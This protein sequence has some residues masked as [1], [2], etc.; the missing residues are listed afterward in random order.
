LTDTTISGQLASF[1]ADLRYEEIPAEVAEHAKLCLLD[2]LGCALFGSALPWTSILEE[3]LEQV[4]ADLPAGTGLPIWGTTSRL[5]APHAAMV[6]GAAAHAFELDD[7]HRESILHAG[8]VVA[9]AVFAAA[10]D[11]VA[12]TEFL[13]ALIA[14]YEVGARVGMALGTPH[15]LQGW[16]PTGTHGTIAAAAAASRALRLDAGQVQ[17]AL[18]LAGSQSAGLM[19]AQFSSMAKRFHAGRAAQSGLYSAL[20]A[21]NG[22]TGITSLLDG[23]YGDYVTTFAPEFDN[24]RIATELGSRWEVA[25]VGFKPYSSNGSCHPTIEILQ[26]MK[27]ASRIGPDDVARV[28]VRVSSATHVHVGWDYVPDSVTTAQMN[29]PYI[30]AVVLAD[31]EAFVDQFTEQRIAD[32]ALVAL[33]RKVEVSADPE[34]DA[35]GPGSRHETHI[36]VVLEDGRILSDTRT[37]ALGSAARPMSEEAVRTKFRRLAE[38]ALA[39]EQVAEVERLVDGLDALADVSVLE[40]A[41]LPGGRP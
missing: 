29:L 34:I 37:S 2:T 31:G 5:T 20:L 19:A 16:H 4:E 17:H 14:G 24:S 28:V 30:A 22:Y 13:A 15:L 27:R 35:R 41:L 6:N 1:V 33:S 7:L 26:E 18:G 36:E 12:G 38:K 3:T 32:P 10:R 40:S 23:S 9:P 11:S 8:A 39:P 21:R 25:K